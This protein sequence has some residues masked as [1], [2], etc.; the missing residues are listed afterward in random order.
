MPEETC[1]SLERVGPG[2]SW[3]KSIFPSLDLDLRLRCA[4]ANLVSAGQAASVPSVQ[5]PKMQRR[6]QTDERR[7]RSRGQGDSSGISVAVAHEAA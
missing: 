3:D 1:V 2:A 5:S 7:G 6:Q 4:E